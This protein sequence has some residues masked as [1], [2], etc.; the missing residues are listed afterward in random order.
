MLA[1]HFPAQIPSPGAST[2]VWVRNII[3]DGLHVV[4]YDGGRGGVT[5]I[6]SAPNRLGQIGAIEIYLPY[7]QAWIINHK[8]NGRGENSYHGPDGD[9]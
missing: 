9:Y 6:G 8:A 3:V 5:Y 1:A 7:I 2:E 4:L